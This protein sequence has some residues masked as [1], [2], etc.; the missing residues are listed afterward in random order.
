MR[1]RRRRNASFIPDWADRIPDGIAGRETLTALGISAEVK[2][3]R[4][5]VVVPLVDENT[6]YQVRALEGFAS[7]SVADSKLGQYVNAGSFPNRASAE[8]R[9]YQLRSQGLDARVAYFP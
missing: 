1:D 9:S 5:V 3:N 8:S 2:K 7:A 4:Y 6:L